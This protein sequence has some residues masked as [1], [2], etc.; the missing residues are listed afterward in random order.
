M[1]VE[2]V[3]QIRFVVIALLFWPCAA[4]AE[5]TADVQ[6]H[7][8]IPGGKDSFQAGEPI[9]LALTFTSVVPGYELNEV[10]TEPASPVDQVLLSP[11]AGVYRLLDDYSRDGR[12]SP[13]YEALYELEP[14]QPLTIKLSLNALYRF[15][16]PGHYTV[17]VITSRVSKAESPDPKSPGPLTSNDVSFDTVPMD[18][19]HE[20]ARVRELESLIR[21]AP[22]LR[23]A[24][25]YADELRWLMGDP[26]TRVKLSLF[27]H[28]KEFYPFGVDVSYGLWVARNRALVVSTLEKSMDDPQQPIEPVSSLLHIAVALKARLES[29]R[30]S[31]ADSTNQLPQASQIED[32]YVRRIAATLPLREGENLVATAITV[33]IFL[34]RREHVDTSDFKVAREAVITHF[35]D[36]DEYEVDWVLNA[37]GK[38]L[39]DGRM[40]PVL[41]NML[42][43]TRF[44]TA[45]D[46]IQN[47]LA[48][49]RGKS[50]N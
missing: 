12:Y 40:I 2:M 6:V 28:P 31:L 35:A 26:S 41:E 34:A 47:Q 21:S 45:R 44:S 27:L 42:D 20:A 5:Q 46:A 17:H 32:E 1:K 49:L 38:Y 7:L 14:G 33:L 22:T 9:T 24:Q 3:A 50:L 43:K 19:A 39:Q 13:D 36:V 18:D 37:Y 10:T 30:Q 15:D 11:G 29:P 4:D 8:S 23:T 25:R 48:L 16:E